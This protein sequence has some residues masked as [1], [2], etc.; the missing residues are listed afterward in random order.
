MQ[1][2]QAIQSNINRLQ[3]QRAALLKRIDAQEQVMRKARTRTLIQLG[4]LVSLSGLLQACDIQEG[5]NLQAD[6][7]AMDKAALLLGILIKAYTELP[8]EIS[9]QDTE[10]LK[11]KGI[12]LL[13]QHHEKRT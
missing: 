13:N 7:E 2:L 1:K 10:E 8:D 9:S 5:D 3:S 12:Q 4:G 6:T 11:K